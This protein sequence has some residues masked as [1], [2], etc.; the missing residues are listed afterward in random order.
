MP[1]LGHSECVSS[2]NTGRT[3]SVANIRK[4]SKG[5]SRKGRGKGAWVGVVMIMI[6]RTATR[7]WR[8]THARLVTSP[9]THHRQIW[10]CRAP[11]RYQ[12]NWMLCPKARWDH[13]L[14]T[15]IVFQ[16]SLLERIAHGSSGATYAMKARARKALNKVMRRKIR[17]CLDLPIFVVLEVITFQW[18]HN[19][20]TTSTITIL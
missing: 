12:Q 15:W 14:G 9:Q 18:M 8:F 6:Q 11:Y 17:Y 13:A 2:S 4:T 1:I 7:N 16:Q 20:L 5:T 3:F 19:I 10:L